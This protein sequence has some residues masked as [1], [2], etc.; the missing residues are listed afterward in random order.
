VA[1]VTDR[2]QLESDL[3][4]QLGRSIVLV[5]PFAMSKG[6]F[7]DAADIII[8]INLAIAALE[9]AGRLVERLK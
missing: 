2:D 1:T 8:S 9:R 4:E 7:R 5:R 3:R 6:H